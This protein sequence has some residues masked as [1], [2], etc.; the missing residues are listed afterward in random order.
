[1]NP[2]LTQGLRKRAKFVRVEDAIEALEKSFE[3]AAEE[4]YARAKAKKPKTSRRDNSKLPPLTP[5]FWE[6]R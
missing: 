6:A 4:L 3:R 5:R 2:G 1:M